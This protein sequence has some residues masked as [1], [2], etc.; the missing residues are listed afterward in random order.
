MV[1]NCTRG[2]ADES[3]G[4]PVNLI[5]LARANGVRQAYR[6]LTSECRIPDRG[7]GNISGMFEEQGILRHPKSYALIIE[8][9]DVDPFLF[10]RFGFESSV[11]RRAVMAGHA[12]AAMTTPHS[13]ATAHGSRFWEGSTRQ[14]R[15]DLAPLGWRAARP[16]QLEV[17]RNEQNTVQITTGLG[18]ANVGN[19]SASPS[20]EHR[21]GTSTL[22]AVSANSRPS[23]ILGQT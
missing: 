1:V 7:C 9:A 2:R 12:D 14:L 15:D 13:P 10:D 8:A 19:R 11:L 23:P 3:Y 17:A 18:D 22:R 20:C 5:R 21:R 16:G 4:H 6:T